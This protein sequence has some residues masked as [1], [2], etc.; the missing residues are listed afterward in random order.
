MAG[1]LG[2]KEES[3]VETRPE[4]ESRIFSVS[5]SD[6]SRSRAF[7]KG[8]GSFFSDLTLQAFVVSCPL[9]GSLRKENWRVVNVLS[10]AWPGACR[11][12]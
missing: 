3:N 6:E 8:G 9:R 7:R 11:M 10:L 1:W 2:K 12:K 5:D 4:V